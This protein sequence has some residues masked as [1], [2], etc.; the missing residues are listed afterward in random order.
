MSR[1]GRSSLGAGRLLGVLIAVG[2]G[3]GI[4]AFTNFAAAQQLLPRGPAERLLDEAQDNEAKSTL[5]V[6]P[7]QAV[8]FAVRGSDLTIYTDLKIAADQRIDVKLTGFGGTA[9][10]ERGRRF[11]L[12][13]TDL[14][15]DGGRSEQV[16]VSAGGSRVQLTRMTRSGDTWSNLT[17]I[18]DGSGLWRRGRSLEPRSERVSLRVRSNQRL[19]GPPIFNAQ[20]DIRAASF[21]ELLRKYP[22]VCFKH[23]LPLF[24]EF[25][26]DLQIFRVDAHLAWQLFPE[27]FSADA[28]TTSKVL[29]LLERLDAQDFRE[30]ELATTELDVIGGAAVMVLNDDD[31]TPLSPEQRTRID[32]VLAR[33]KQLDSDQLATLLNDSEFLLRCFVYGE[34]EAIRAAAVHV[35]GQKFGADKVAALKPGSNLAARLVAADDVRTHLP[36]PPSPQD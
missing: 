17:L 28:A 31:R 13:Y 33:F 25:N 30:R 19:G 4:G 11:M 21:E 12:T 8:R 10:V 18:Q 15:E 6:A 29:A 26:Q 22:G 14:D 27:A 34:T 35:M 23:L 24:R 3:V 5:Q 9:Q 20:V 2:I 1:A 32:A 7:E 36:A 16:I